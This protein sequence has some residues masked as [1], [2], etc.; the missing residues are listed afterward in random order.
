MVS[1]LNLAADLRNVF[2]VCKVMGFFNDTYYRHKALIADGGLKA[3]Q[4]AN[5]KKPN[6]RNI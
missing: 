6:V 5:R 3:L 2:R 4:N 1:L